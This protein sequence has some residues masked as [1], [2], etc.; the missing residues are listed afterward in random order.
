MSSTPAVPE[1]KR[2]LVTGGTGF[3]GPEVLRLLGQPGN[4]IVEHLARHGA[5]QGPRVSI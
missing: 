1:P 4:W 5:G 2:A 3:V